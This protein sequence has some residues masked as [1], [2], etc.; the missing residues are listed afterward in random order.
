ME[1]GWILEMGRSW[2]FDVYTE[3]GCTA[4]QFVSGTFGEDERRINE[5]IAYHQIETSRRVSEEQKCRRG[6]R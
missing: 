1:R 6:A 4:G 3:R 5:E 2:G